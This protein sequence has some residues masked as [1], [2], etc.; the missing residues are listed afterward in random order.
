MRGQLLV[1]V[2][3][4]LCS[5]GGGS[6]SPGMD[7]APN[8]LGTWVGPL[9][10]NV[11]GQTSQELSFLLRITQKSCGDAGPCPNELLLGSICPDQSAVP[12]SVTS[13]TTFYVP[14]YSCPA[15]PVFGCGSSVVTAAG[16][17]TLD[18]STLSFFLSG[19]SSGCGLSPDYTQSF[20]GQA[21]AGVP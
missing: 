12:A 7:F 11:G 17:G 8:F 19:T 6:D 16:L 13:A 14:T 4:F 15:G 10:L 9:S 5:C 1:I 21:D 18:G 20:Q 3:V 2:A